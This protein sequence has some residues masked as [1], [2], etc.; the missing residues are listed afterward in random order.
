MRICFL[1]SGNKNRNGDINGDTIRTGGVG[2]SGTDQSTIMVAEYIAAQGQNEVVIATETNTDTKV[3]R[4]VTYTHISMKDL[5]DA[6]R[7]FDVLLT[8][9]WFAEF[10]NLPIKVTRGV[11]IVQHM[12]YVYSSCELQSFLSKNPGLKVG[13]VHVSEWES[14]RTA[15][16]FVSLFP[17]CRQ[18]VIYNP[19]MTDLIQQVAEENHARKKHAMVF[20]ASWNRG[21]EMC[22]V[23]FQDYLTDDNW[24]DK[25]L[26]TSDYNRC[27]LSFHTDS[28]IHELGS[29]DK[30]SLLRTLAKCS[31]FVYPCVNA[32][33]GA[34]HHDTFGCVVAEA[35]AMGVRVV[36]YPMGAL[37]EV[38]GNLLTYVPF[39]DSVDVEGIQAGRVGDEPKLFDPERYANVLRN[40]DDDAYDYTIARDEV[41][42]RFSIDVI[43]RQWMDFLTGYFP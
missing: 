28:R 1:L 41:M 15:R 25:E 29:Q 19:I 21:A 24:T 43:G 17:G 9:L 35:L 26:Y 18:V 36:C 2:A 39:P 13:V 12:Q 5:S 40:M 6:E 34:L 7:T 14:A 27:T 31:Y 20:T 3:I 42:R 23:L 32:G 22:K 30:V 10:E 11:I 37:P 8:M 4:G 16:H 38:Y 33:P